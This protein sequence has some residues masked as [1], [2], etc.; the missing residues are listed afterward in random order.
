M[1]ETRGYSLEFI[2]DGFLALHSRSGNGIGSA[3]GS[4][5]PG[6]GGVMK[7]RKRMKRL[8]TGPVLFPEALVEGVVTSS[9]ELQA[10]QVQRQAPPPTSGIMRFEMGTV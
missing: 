10:Q 4:Q 8:L 3:S 9:M 2:Q 1:P 6:G 5:Q 7:I